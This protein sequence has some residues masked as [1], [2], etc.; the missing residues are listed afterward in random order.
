MPFRR[1]DVKALVP[2]MPIVVTIDRNEDMTQDAFWQEDLD[3][4]TTVNLTA[5]EIRE[6]RDSRSAV[7]SFIRQMAATPQT[8]AAPAPVG[9]R[10]AATAGGWPI[11]LIN[12][13]AS[14]STLA[15]RAKLVDTGA[16][17]GRITIT[18]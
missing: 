1:G 2:G 11:F 7:E 15:R 18:A 12:N 14:T 9:Q 16:N 17:Q 4:P 6:H 8:V 10:R 13:Q 5:S 3:P